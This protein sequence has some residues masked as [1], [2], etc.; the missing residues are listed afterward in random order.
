MKEYLIV[1]LF[2]AIM[3]FIIGWVLIDNL[4]DP[5]TYVEAHDVLD[6]EGK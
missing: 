1:F 6:C 4:P 5:C 3:W 2:S